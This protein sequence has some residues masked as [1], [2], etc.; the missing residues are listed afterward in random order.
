MNHMI[1]W[2]LWKLCVLLGQQ[3]PPLSSPDLRLWVA[4]HHEVRD[5]IFHH[6]FLHVTLVDCGLTAKDG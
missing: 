3:A 5:L 4:L 1:V 2:M 6:A